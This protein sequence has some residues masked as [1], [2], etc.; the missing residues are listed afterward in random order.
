MLAAAASDPM[1]LVYTWPLVVL[2]ALRCFA[3]DAMPRVLLY[4]AADPSGYI[5]AARIPAAEAL[6]AV[7]PSLGIDFTQTEDRSEFTDAKLAQYDALMFLLTSGD[8]EKSL[9]LSR[10]QQI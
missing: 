6:K 4:T 5:H 2:L 9:G 1:S 7:G 10:R 8:G 3:Q